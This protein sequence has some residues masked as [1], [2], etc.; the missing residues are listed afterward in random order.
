MEALDERLEIRVPSQTM[1]LL[2]EEARQRGVSVAQ[3]VRDAIAHQVEDDRLA[4]IRAAE[5]LCQVDAPVADWDEMKDEI[6]TARQNALGAARHGEP[7]TRRPAGG[8]R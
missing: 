1:R 4:R 8:G 7:V 6:V 2:R 3:V 5:A